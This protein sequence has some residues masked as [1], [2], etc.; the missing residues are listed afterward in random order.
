MRAGLVLDSTKPTASLATKGGENTAG[1]GSKYG[2]N[3]V[4]A[5]N[6]I[7]SAVKVRKHGCTHEIEFPSK[8]ARLID[9]SLRWFFL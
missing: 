5:K 2:E 6:T 4:T 8:P 9:R 7:F 1:L 3:T